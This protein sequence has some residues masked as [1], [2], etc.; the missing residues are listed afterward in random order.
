MTETE[1]MRE[2]VGYLENIKSF[3]LAHQRSERSTV[4]MIWGLFILIAGFIDLYIS[5]LVGYS[6]HAG[7]W[8]FIIGGA[9]LAQQVI[10]SQPL[11]YD[12]SFTDD[13]QRDRVTPA[14]VVVIIILMGLTIPISNANFILVMPYIGFTFGT[15]N[16]A[17]LIRSKKKARYPI[18]IISAFYAA[19]ILILSLYLIDPEYA[20]YGGFI[21]GVLVGSV[22]FTM[23]FLSRKQLEIG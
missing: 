1:E 5:I 2:L 22:T 7:V 9:L 3:E 13:V 16:L 20:V 4:A 11:L 15:I 21:F 23:A 18:G 14:E 17:G 10:S 6:P 12:E 8:F 19:A